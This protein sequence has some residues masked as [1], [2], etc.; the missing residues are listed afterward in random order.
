MQGGNTPHTGYTFRL[1]MDN[2]EGVKVYML[3][4]LRGKPP[5]RSWRILPF[6]LIRASCLPPIVCATPLKH[7]SAHRSGSLKPLVELS[8]GLPFADRKKCM[9]P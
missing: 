4:G 5:P 7:H 3:P 8:N 2:F 6:F 9:Q 1:P